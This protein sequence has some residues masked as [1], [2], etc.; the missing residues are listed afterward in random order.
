MKMSPT[1]LQQKLQ[2]KWRFCTPTS[3]NNSLF[4]EN[5]EHKESFNYFCP[6]KIT[7]FANRIL[8][9]KDQYIPLDIPRAFVSNLINHFKKKTKMTKT[10]RT[11]PW[12]TKTKK[13]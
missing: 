7:N 9:K 5:M 11:F 4:Y 13:N 3:I 6:G 12:K 2:F 1:P 10:S 8:A